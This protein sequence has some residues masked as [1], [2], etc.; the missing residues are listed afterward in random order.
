MAF[1]EIALKALK[2][3]VGDENVT[4]DPVHCQSYSRVQWTAD[5]CIQR[6]QLGL[7]MRPNCVVMAGSTEEVQ[8]IFKLANRYDLLIC[9]RRVLNANSIHIMFNFCMIFGNTEKATFKTLHSSSP[10]EFNIN[11]IPLTS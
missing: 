4:N 5:G 11:Q 2:D 3:V 9:A 8:A 1:S 10:L 6:S 7:G